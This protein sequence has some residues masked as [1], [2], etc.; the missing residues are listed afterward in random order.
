M[1]MITSTKNETIKHIKALQARPKSRREAGAFIVEGIRLAEEAVNSGWLTHLCL[2][3]SELNQRGLAVVEQLREA[4]VETLE[5]APHVIA[6]ASNTR[7]PQGI[8]LKL[9][10]APPP[11]PED[12]TFILVLDQLRDPGNVGTLL[13][14]A[15][16]ASV[17]A[18][19]LSAGSADAFSPK[20]LRSGM[21]AQFRL[22]VHSM[23]PKEIISFC[24]EQRLR[25]L[26]AEAN[27]GTPYHLA[28]LKSPFA[29]IVGSEA[30]GPSTGFQS[31]ADGYLQIQMP[32][33]TESLNAAVAASIMIFETVRQ[34]S[35]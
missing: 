20:V 10:L 2:Y 25:I 11:I 32:G 16:A 13:R 19:L 22:P 14:T 17:D 3:S 1:M 29:L 6:A 9:D 23:D 15:A 33:K 28:D 24:K 30:H 12:P 35:S 4:G 18:V 7:T 34:R 31:D 27:K 8:L 21:G 26:L 5:A